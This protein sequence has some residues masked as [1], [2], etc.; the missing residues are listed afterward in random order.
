[1]FLD[2]DCS[3]IKYTDYASR[4]FRDI[5]TAEDIYLRG[6]SDP[7]EINT[8]LQNKTRLDDFSIQLNMML[9]G[10]FCEFYGHGHVWVG[11]AILQDFHWRKGECTTR[12]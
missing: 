6:Y 2:V 10:K 4:I 7:S 8:I 12:G 3:D 1:M 5:L 9:P 11:L